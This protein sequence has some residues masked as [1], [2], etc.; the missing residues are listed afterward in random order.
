ML[1][2]RGISK[3]FGGVHALRDVSLTVAPGTVHALVGENG[4][5]KSTLGRIAAGVLRP[6]AGEVRLDGAVVRWRSPREARAA[7][8]AMVH[9]E[10]A[11]CPDL[12]VAENVALGAWPTRG[13]LVDRAAM[14]RRAEEL[15]AGIGARLDVGAP[16]RALSVAQ[17]QLVQIAAAVGTGARLLV[18]DEP[19]SALAEA[20]A[21]RL[22]ELVEALRA[23]GTTI[24]YVSHRLSEVLRLADQITV[25]RD[26]R[27]TET[28]PGLGTTA[29][30][31]VRLMCGR[32]VHAAPPAGCVPGAAALEVE[33]LASAG[34]FEDVNFRVCAGEIVGLAGLVG[35]GR[36]SIARALF[37][38]DPRVTGRVR[39][40]GRP[41][42]LR[43]TG[44][45]LAAGLAL[46]PEDRQRQGLITSWDARS[47]WSLPRLSAFAR[48]GVVA[49]GREARAAREALAAADVR[50]EQDAPV[51]ALSGVNQQKVALAR[52]LG[53][54]P[55]VLI[56]DEPTR[57]VD[58]GA[59]AA[60]HAR[61][62]AFADEG[63]A[64]LLISSEL[65]ELLALADRV[66]VLRGGRIAAE[67][68]RGAGEEEVLREMAGVGST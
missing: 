53:V 23:R 8:V 19:T 6:D 65:P 54:A 46:L 36:S 21:A 1:E 26:G 17:V 48:A 30:Q 29:G 4:A 15:L 2:L 32:E 33:E 63:H 28:R 31:C 51:A 34:V 11:V 64:V 62:R 5:G 61:L 18:L 14:T 59:K 9:Q 56:A 3:H 44:A 68:R 50:G 10:L 57:G 35:A 24:V 60:I 45:A 66:L 55:R 52:W 25:L 42:R 7:G 12:S 58:V 16:L 43:R 41:L 13:P 47:N 39:V 22:M 37:G 20:E 40:D 27:V 67:L 49:R 38:L